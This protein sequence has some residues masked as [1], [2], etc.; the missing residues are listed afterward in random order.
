MGESFSNLHPTWKQKYRD[1]T[2]TARETENRGERNGIIGWGKEKSINRYGVWCC[3]EKISERNNENL[4][5]ENNGQ[6]YHSEDSVRAF[7]KSNFGSVNSTKDQQREKVWSDPAQLIPKPQI[8]LKV[9]AFL[10]GSCWIEQVRSIRVIIFHN[11]K[12]ETIPCFKII[13]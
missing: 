13:K 4:S 12:I 5:L 9:I 1:P 7:T 2:H 8:I 6:K 10:C 3:W 11:P